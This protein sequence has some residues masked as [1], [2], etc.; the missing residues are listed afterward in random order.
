MTRETKRITTVCLASFAG[1]VGVISSIGF[2]ANLQS[3]GSWVPGATPM[4]I[5]TSTCFIVLSAAVILL[6]TPHDSTKPP[7]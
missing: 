1:S 3:L 6:S 4:A 7:R 2:L 5:S